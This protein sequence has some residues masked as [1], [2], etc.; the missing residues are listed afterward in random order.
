M[1]KSL[2]N[3]N[4]NRTYNPSGEQNA[5]CDIKRLLTSRDTAAQSKACTYLIDV[6][7]RYEK[8]SEER[9]RL[10]Q[11]LLDNDIIVFLGEVTCN[12]D[13]NLFRLVLRCIRLVWCTPRFFAEEH[14]SH[15]LSAVVR[16]I[17]HFIAINPCALDVCLHFICDLLSGIS[18]NKT[19]SPLS[20]QSAYST[21]QLLASFT[22]IAT[23]INTISNS[24]SILSSA[25]VLQELISYQPEGLI[26]TSC[27]AQ[28]LVDVI[29]KWL[30]LLMMGLNHKGLT[31]EGDEIGMLL[32]VTCQIIMDSLGLIKIFE[33]ARPPADFVNKILADN[34][35]VDS[36]RECANA[37]RKYIHQVLTEMVGFVKDNLETIGTVEYSGFVKLVLNFYYEASTEV[38][39][40]FSEVLLS[41]GYLAI[42]PK[43]QLERRDASLRKVSTLVLGEMLKIL[44]EKYLL[45]E[46]SGCKEISAK[47]VHMGLMEL[48]NGVESPQNIGM[49]LQKNQPYSILIY[50][51]FYCQATDNPEEVTSHLLPHLV[52]HILCLPIQLKPPSYIIKALWL[53]FA[54]STISNGSLDSLDER[55][56]LEKA[57]DRLVSMLQPEPA[58]YYTHNPAILF[59]AFT[60]SRIPNSMRL[61]VLSQWFKTETVLPEG[62]TNEPLVWELLLDVVMQVKDADVVSNCMKGLSSCMEDGGDDVKRNFGDRVWL[63]L[64]KILSRSLV[65]SEIGIDINVCHILDVAISLPP[66]D[67]DKDTCDK[68]AFLL[69][70]LYSKNTD[71]FTNFEAK[72]H[73]QYVCLSLS[74]M[75]LQF[76]CDRH[77]S[78]VLLIFTNKPIYLANVLSTIDSNDENVAC[79]ALDLLSFLV[80]YYHK[81]G[82]RPK[83]H[84][85]IRT[86]YLVKSLRKD[87]T[88]VRTN[89]LLQLID[90][91]LKSGCNTPLVLSDSLQNGPAQE[92]QCNALR[93]LMFRIQISLCSGD[94]S[95]RT[96]TG[97]QTLRTI[98]EHL[99]KHKRDAKLVALLSCQPWFHTL[100]RFQITQEKATEFFDF[101]ELWLKLLKVTIQLNRGE[102]RV[103]S[104]NGMIG[105]TMLILKKSLVEHQDA[106]MVV[107]EI[108]DE[109]SGRK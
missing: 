46:N 94:S 17:N 96:S 32:I 1:Y 100:I 48:Q 109:C 65:D 76:S 23:R 36:L 99:T 62:F 14:A 77:D 53:V 18:T 102:R 26:V 98:F 24:K 29:K 78:K 38:L 44:S 85:A 49:Q 93:A 15:S 67:F 68:T 80:C 84:L 83:S 64:P 9:N 16:A 41:N 60:S 88:S 22:N 6:I 66:V 57:S 43:A 92:Q 37:M 40:E 105:R 107:E 30:E 58:V 74:L 5:L 75:L 59:W 86:D 3:S 31:A 8:D 28:S 56:Y 61:L 106:A 42:L 52:Q 79:A 104:K 101:L 55:V 21:E 4:F 108:L 73:Y 2:I 95:N 71:D 19:T 10:A 27:V 89:S 90:T 39:L 20:H 51:Y 63:L 12:L 50:I 13:F 103:I 72:Y 33:Q 47:D 70:T 7:S 35:E 34:K 54:M 69:T 81:N 25:L 11:Y 87:N 82:Y 91:V 97:W 45:V